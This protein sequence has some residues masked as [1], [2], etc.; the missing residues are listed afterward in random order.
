N[1]NNNNKTKLSCDS[2]PRLAVWLFSLAAFQSQKPDELRAS[3]CRTPAMTCG[4][5]VVTIVA[6]AVVVAVVA[7]AVVAV[8]VVVI[9]GVVVVVVASRLPPMRR[10][11]AEFFSILTD[12]KK[13]VPVSGPLYFWSAPFF[14]FLLNTF[15]SDNNKLLSCRCCCSCCC[16]CLLR[17]LSRASPSTHVVLGGCKFK[18]HS[19]TTKH[20]YVVCSCV[21]CS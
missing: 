8:A 18:A 14:R 7:V 16:S 2:L 5:V 11:C 1:K 3:F 13:H 6:A 17:S 4:F 20:L 9:A 12:N 10:H 19:D 21:C 15:S